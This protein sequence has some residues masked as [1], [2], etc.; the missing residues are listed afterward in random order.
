MDNTV[1]VFNFHDS[2][3]E[4]NY[5]LL[6]FKQHRIINSVNLVKSSSTPKQRYTN[7]KYINHQSC[8]S[9]T[10]YQSHIYEPE[11]INVHSNG[12][13]NVQIDS[14]ESDGN[15]KRPNMA[16]NCNKSGKSW[17]SLFANKAVVSHQRIE[18]K[19]EDDVAEMNSNGNLEMDDVSIPNELTS[20]YDDPN[21]YRMGGSHAY[22]HQ[23]SVLFS[24]F[25]FQNFWPT[26]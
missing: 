21:Y 19:F 6:G 9:N 8:D 18:V 1:S 25:S 23:K 15:E 2:L 20:K 11:N 24:L 5:W 4:T 12:V 17:A 22:N 14:V 10:N 16:S 13:N 3:H 26:M 7:I